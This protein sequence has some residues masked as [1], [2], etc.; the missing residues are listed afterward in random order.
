MSVRCT[1][2]VSCPVSKRCYTRKK[3]VFNNGLLVLPKLLHKNAL[4]DAG[5]GA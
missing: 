5:T 4:V 3:L 1:I 2:P